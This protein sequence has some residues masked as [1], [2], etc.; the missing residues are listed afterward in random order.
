[1]SKKN[2]KDRK[3]RPQPKPNRQIPNSLIK[4]MKLFGPEYYLLHAREYPIFGCWIMEGWHEAGITPI[5]VAREY[6]LG[7]VMCAVCMVDIYCLGIKGAYVKTDLSISSFERILPKMCINEPEKCTVELAHEIIY[8]G[9][10]YAAHYGFQPHPDFTAQHADLVLDPADAHPRLDNVAFGKDGK[11]FY[12]AGP[13]DDE[14]KKTFIFE[15]LMRTAGKDN[16]E[17]IIA[18]DGLSEDLD[19]EDL[20]DLFDEEELDED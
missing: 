19:D 10:E 18:V 13:Y 16:F 14:R 12:F 11:P 5:V 2:K 6:E 1:M 20:I 9:M 7:K 15:T 3:P 8:G 17:F 4:T